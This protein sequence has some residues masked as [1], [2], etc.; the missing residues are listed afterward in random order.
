MLNLALGK[1]DNIS[2]ACNQK[3]KI[4]KTASKHVETSGQD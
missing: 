2:G 4:R 3:N 1:F